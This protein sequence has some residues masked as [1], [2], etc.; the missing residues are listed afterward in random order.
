MLKEFATFAGGCFWCM[1]HLF[2][3]L[4]GVIKTTVGYTGGSKEQAFY[5]LVSAG[6]TA[7]RE[8]IQIVYDSEKIEY[9]KL[10]ELFL[11]HIDPTNNHGQFFD[12]GSQYRTAV[13]YHSVEQKAIV[14][15]IFQEILKSGQLESIFTEILPA[16]PFYSAEDYHQHYAKN[17]PFAYFQYARACGRNEKLKQLWPK[18]GE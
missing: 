1:Q 3:E 16:V 17:H 5:T 15:S 14:E 7:H 4:P 9:N 8:A 18:E 6:H 12:I 10:V 11:H 13:Y 2:D